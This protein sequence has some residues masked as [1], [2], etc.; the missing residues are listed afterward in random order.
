MQDQRERERAKID[1]RACFAGA[2]YLMGVGLIFLLG[3]VGAPD[4]LVQALGPLFALSGVALLGAL[5]RSTRVPT[6]FIADRA[7]PAVYAGLSFAAFAAG[8]FLCLGPPSAAPLP[9]AGVAIGLSV[10]GLIVGPLLRASGASALSDLLATRFPNPLLKAIFTGLL[11]AIG[12]FI[13]IAGFEAAID[14]F[15]ALFA[16]ARGAAEA[17]VAAILVLMIA[18]GGLAGLLWGGAAS[19]GILIIILLLP[20]VAQFFADDAAIGVALRDAGLWRDAVAQG[21][22]PGDVHDPGTSVLVVLASALAV[23]ALAPFTSPAIASFRA[24]QASRAGAFGL[25]FVALIGL[26]AFIDLVVWPSPAGPMSSGLKASALLLA[27]LALCSAGVHSASRARGTNAGGAYSRY[28]PLASQRLARSRALTLAII[29]LCAGLT[30]RLAIDPKAAIVVAAALSLSLVAP[31]LALAFS[32]RATASHAIAC[33]AV[34]LTTAVVLIVLERRIPGAERLLIG[35]L[36]A[37]GAGFVAGW[38]GAVFSRGERDPNPA[39]RDIF[40]DAPLD[41]SG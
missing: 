27:A 23:A 29:A 22:G 15:V 8:L 13:A 21:W 4:G 35:A 18:P 11:L 36:C 39:R 38:G 37:G 2:A 40:V 41:P 3:R 12:I 24:G 20:I 28:M 19:A 1:G 16:P 32:S 6:F 17:I 9:L 5:T 25:F 26:A 7:I 30:W 10:N 31:A 14:A 33:V 34:S